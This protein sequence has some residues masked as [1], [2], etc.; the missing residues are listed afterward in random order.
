MGSLSLVSR[1]RLLI[2][3]ILSLALLHGLIYVFTVPPWEHY[4]EPNHFEYVWLTANLDRLPTEADNSAKLS[5]MV[6]K[7]MIENGFYEHRPNKPVVGPTSEKLVVPGYSQLGDPP[8]YYVLASLPLRLLSSS[9]IDVQLYSAR[10][11]SVIF[12]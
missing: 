9:S 4:D 8:G 11:V 7:S 3:L 2:C 6:V 10:L 1:D 12:L 5:R